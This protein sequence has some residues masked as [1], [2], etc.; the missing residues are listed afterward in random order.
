MESEED[1]NGKDRVQNIV[2][3]KF[4]RRLSPVFKIHEIVCLSVLEL[5]IV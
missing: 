5:E 1:S 2:S 3:E 4:L